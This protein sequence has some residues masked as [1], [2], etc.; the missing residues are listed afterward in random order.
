MSKEMAIIALGIWVVILPHLGVPGS[1]H[2]AITTI[3]GIV[4]IAAGLY[5]RAAM[6]ASGG[7]R[8]PHHPFVENTE[9]GSDRNHEHGQEH[10]KVN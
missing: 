9:D 1:W 8:S 5:F 6:L 7:R 4:I 10:P 2:T 3:T